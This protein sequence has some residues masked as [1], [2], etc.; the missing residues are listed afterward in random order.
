MET[1]TVPRGEAVPAR[2]ASRCPASATASATAPSMPA[3]VR[4]V[5]PWTGSASSCPRRPV[6]SVRPARRA[7]SQHVGRHDHGQPKVTTGEHQGQVALQV[8]GVRD[9]E[10]GIGPLGKQLASLPEGAVA[11]GDRSARGSRAGP[12]ATRRAQPPGLADVPPRPWCPARWRSRRPT[13]GTPR[14][15][16]LLPTFGRPTRATTGRTGSMVAERVAAMA[17]GR[18]ERSRTVMRRPNPG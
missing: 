17:P 5:V 2:R 15:N 18:V 10:D 3:P 7:S 14:A 11:S 13:T 9:H 12:R 16:V 8:A 4:P 6:S 1:G